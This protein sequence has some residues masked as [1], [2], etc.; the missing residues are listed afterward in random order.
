[1]STINLNPVQQTTE[2]ARSKIQVSRIVRHAPDH[3]TLQIIVFQQQD[4][5]ILKKIEGFFRLYNLISL[6]NP[7]S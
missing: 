6:D 1:M 5:N 2:M 3:N 7:L 4:L